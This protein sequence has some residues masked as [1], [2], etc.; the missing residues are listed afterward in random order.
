MPLTVLLVLYVQ[1]SAAGLR[2]E[3]KEGEKEGQEAEASGQRGGE[4]QGQKRRKGERGEEGWRGRR[5]F[6]LSRGMCCFRRV[7]GGA[8]MAMVVHW[9]LKGGV[10]G[11]RAR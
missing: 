3:R 5:L 4:G 6:R 1:N 11:R 10:G 2:E 7:R 8:V 9:R